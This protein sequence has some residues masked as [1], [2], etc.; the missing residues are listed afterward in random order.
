MARRTV[1]V[2]KKRNSLKKRRG[3]IGKK[4]KAQKR[5]GSRRR[6]R[7]IRGGGEGKNVLLIIDPQ[8][9]FVDING[10]G[11]IPSLGVGNASKDLNLVVDMLKTH[12]D[13][14][15]EIHVSL[16][17]HTKTHIAHKGFW[18]GGAKDF[19]SLT[20]EGTE[21]DPVFKAGEI[22]VTPY[23]NRLNKSAYKY[24]KT[25]TQKNKTDS[26]KPY[27][28]IWP[29][30]CIF[31]DGTG[32]PTEGWKIYKPLA[33]ALEK[34][35]NKVFYHEKGT[36]D[37]VEMYSIFSSEVPFS[38]V[39]TQE[40]LEVYPKYENAT[41]PDPNNIINQ[42]NKTRNYNT[43]FNFKLFKYLMGDGGENKVFVCGEAK[44]HCVKTSLEDMIAH[45]E[46]SGGRRF[47]ASKIYAIENMMSNIVA[48]Y[49]YTN[50]SNNAFAKMKEKGLNIVQSNSLSTIL[51]PP[52]AVWK[53]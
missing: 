13:K 25:L 28:L 19:D 40:A 46:Q 36:N 43:N 18:K 35:N 4:S 26:T 17:T 52:P 14:F 42:L 12:A 2:M 53:L 47:K 51:T 37:L 1:R 16:D 34:L 20:V 21:N 23:D 30:H 5:S 3:A 41:V 15:H 7:V 49:D 45:C 10:D 44:S 32:T 31:D 33:D 9:D 11:H 39:S 6:V 8:K 50:D 29:D 38:E 24:I 48:P 22:V 27:P